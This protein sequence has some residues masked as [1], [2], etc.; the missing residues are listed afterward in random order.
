MEA[1]LHQIA[2][3]TAA[4]IAAHAKADQRAAQSDQRL[5][6]MADA[7]QQQMAAQA[8]AAQQVQQQMQAQAAAA[9]QQQQQQQAA[10]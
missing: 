1:V 4:N 9:Q 5:Q 2:Q 6:I 7:G 10:A 3:A 8:A